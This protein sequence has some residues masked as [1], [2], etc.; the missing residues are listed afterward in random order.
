MSKSYADILTEK[1]FTGTTAHLF[2]DLKQQ[3]LYLSYK[4]ININFVHFYILMLRGKLEEINFM[5]YKSRSTNTHFS[6]VASIDK[7]PSVG[8]KMEKQQNFYF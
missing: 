6:P 1:S 3:T 7:R 4:N 5:L 2:K 8:D